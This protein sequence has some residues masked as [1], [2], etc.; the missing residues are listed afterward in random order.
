M[1][2][3]IGKIHSAFITINGRVVLDVYN[4]SSHYFQSIAGEKKR[5]LSKLLRRRYGIGVVEWRLIM[6]LARE[7]DIAASEL[8]KFTLTDKAQVSKA[9]KALES[10]ELI[11][12]IP[13]TERSPRMNFELTEKGDQLHD[14]FLPILFKR[15]SALFADSNEAEIEQFFVMLKRISKNLIRFNAE[16]MKTDTGSTE[17]QL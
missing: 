6:G 4:F 10:K 5:N 17:D 7:P 12:L 9:L 1:I 13:K 14:E 16:E 8:S 15:E 11:K 3:E 2:G